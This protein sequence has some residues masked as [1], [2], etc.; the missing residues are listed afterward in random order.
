MDFDFAPFVEAFVSGDYPKLA[1][2]VLVALAAL[3]A[4]Y[5][6]GKWPVLGPVADFLKRVK[7]AD[8]A[9]VALPQDPVPAEPPEGS[10]LAG[11]KVD[12]GGPEGR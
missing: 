2:L 8:K 6:S 5:F 4:R 11:V 3:A 1:V 7:V 12:S 10:G 9:P